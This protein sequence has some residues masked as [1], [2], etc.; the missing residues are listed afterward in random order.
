MGL[1]ELKNVVEVVIDVFET[2][3]AVAEPSRSSGVG[4][5]SPGLE[6]A[7]PI[8][9]VGDQGV[10]SAWKTDGPDVVRDGWLGRRWTVEIFVRE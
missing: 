5:G 10:R 8:L 9:E 6:L 4:L 7:D 1:R 2:A 3:Q